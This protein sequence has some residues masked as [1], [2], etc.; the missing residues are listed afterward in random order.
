MTL[1]QR[2]QSI[3]NHMQSVELCL[4]QYKHC[5]DSAFIINGFYNIDHCVAAAARLP[6]TISPIFS[7]SGIF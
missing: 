5:F 6:V 4:R 3:I 1:S 7:G 2:Q